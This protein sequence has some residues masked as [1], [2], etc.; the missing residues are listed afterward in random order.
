MITSNSWRSQRWWERPSSEFGTRRRPSE[1]VII[2]G[3]GHAS[4]STPRRRRRT[5]PSPIAG[6]ALTRTPDGDVFTR[7]H[8]WFVMNGAGKGIEVTTGSTVGTGG[9]L[10]SQHFGEK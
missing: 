3:P 7:D 10:V 6:H 9:Q 5:F 8:D 4:S 2:I 1:L